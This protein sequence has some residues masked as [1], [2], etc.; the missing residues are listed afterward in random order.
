MDFTYTHIFD[1]TACVI[2]YIWY[3][4]INKQQWQRCEKNIRFLIRE[5]AWERTVKYSFNWTTVLAQTN[6][7]SSTVLC[8]NI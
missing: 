5:V 8:V 2:A 6:S 4:S 1:R 3:R 7:I